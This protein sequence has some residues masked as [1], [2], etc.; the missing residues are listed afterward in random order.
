VIPKYDRAGF[1]DWLQS[2]LDTAPDAPA[3]ARV[4]QMIDDLEGAAALR[5]PSS[6]VPARPPVRGWA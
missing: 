5:Q 2:L 3:R 4:Q 6:S 1:R